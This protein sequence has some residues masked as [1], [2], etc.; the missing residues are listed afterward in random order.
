[1][2]DAYKVGYGRPPKT[3]QFKKGQSGNPHGSSRKARKRKRRRSLSLDDHVLEN[4]EKLLRL[5]EG[6]RTSSIS[7]KEA[8]VKKQIAM[9]ITGNRLALQASLNR[10]DEAEKNK[11]AKVLDNYEFFLDYKESYP[12]R[13]M[14]N[15]NNGLPP[16]LPHPDDVRF[17]RCTGETT[18]A[19]PLDREELATLKKILEARKV[20]MTMLEEH[21]SDVEECARQGYPYSP[22]ELEIISHVAKHLRSFDDELDRRGWLPR[23]A[24]EQQTKMN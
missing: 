8:L 10:I 6:N 19:G 4:S 11:L 13:A 21:R 1:M 24:G 17:D 18:F 12:R 16:P 2:T 20:F 5:R 22:S 7:T 9:G 14:N 15:R 23:V 3:S